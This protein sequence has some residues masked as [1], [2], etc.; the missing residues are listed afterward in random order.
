MNKD[1]DFKSIR[2]VGERIRTHGENDILP[3]DHIKNL[4]KIVEAIVPNGRH[5]G[6]YDM[7]EKELEEHLRHPRRAAVVHIKDIR[8]PDII[9]MIMDDYKGM[10]DKFNY[11]VPISQEFTDTYLQ[12]SENDIKARGTPDEAKGTIPL[13]QPMIN[14]EPVGEKVS[15]KKLYVLMGGTLCDEIRL[16]S[17]KGNS[18]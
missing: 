6:I 7:D 9:K 3:L 16:P 12:E 11:V 13:W 2:P 8:H 15:A 10:W 1:F 18:E 14:G 17:L 4:N 5:R